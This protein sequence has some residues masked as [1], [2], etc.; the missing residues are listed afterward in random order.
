MSAR[1]AAE[2]AAFESF[3]NCYLREVD[4]GVWTE[5]PVSP[6]G[7]SHGIELA[8]DSQGARL[9]LDVVSLSLCGPHQLGRPFLRRDGETV[10]RGLAPFDAL[11]A[12]LREAYARIGGAASD[13][14]RGCELELLG[15]ALDSYQAIA[16]YLERRGGNVREDDGFLAAEQSLAFGHWLHPTP[17]S[18]QGMTEWQRK[19]YAPEL[20]GRFRLTFFAADSALIR[21]DSACA[22][23]APDIVRGLMGDAARSLR[24]EET[25]IPMHPLQAEA[26]LL[27]PRVAALVASG[28]LRPLGSSGPLF[29][30]T[31]S[32]RTVYAPDAPFMLKF[33]LP[34]RITNSVRVS[35]LHELEAGAAVARLFGRTDWT[36]RNPR[37]RILHDP[38][39]LTLDLGDGRES[40]FEVIFRD[41]PFVGDAGRGVA[42]VAALAAAPAPGETSRLETLVRRLADR[43]R[44]SVGR[45]AEAWFSA[46]LDCAIEPPIALYDEL[47]VALEAH[48]QNSVLDVSALRPSVC[49]YR[50]SQ[51]FYLSN[52]HRERLDA[53][54][55]E[56]SGIA[57]L[58]FDDAEIRERFGYYLIVNQAFSVISRLGHDGL[59]DEYAMVTL[60]R[61]RLERLAVRLPGVG[62][63]FARDLLDR[64]TLAAKANLVTR[65]YGID[66][67]SENSGAAVYGATP[68]PIAAAGAARDLG[69]VVAV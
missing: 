22:A 9:R 38:A 59:A 54:C 39:H 50:D 67:L 37:F 5:R 63:A 56:A 41:N 65:L 1:A 61:R 57:G 48:Q 14:L 29:S 10:W 15:R 43:E 66:E 18:L 19:A 8:L 32:V 62:G 68:N 27:E 4:G 49:H 2:H 53:L 28:R 23:A 16:A 13:A 30:A 52:A 34:V 25:A 47:G 6:A 44:L 55:P 17:K 42:A 36:A 26:L 12:L 51:G 3:A 40:G 45:A 60:L 20:H 31:S 11:A 33:S 46:Y 64:P 69:H 58:Y 24:P 7:S 35:R 21:H